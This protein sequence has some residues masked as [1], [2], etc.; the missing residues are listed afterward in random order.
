MLAGGAAIV[1]IV[2]LTLV[3]VAHV[4]TRDLKA[5]QHDLLALGA[6]LAEQAERSVQGIDLVVNAV[7]DELL[8]GGIATPQELER[9]AVGAEQHERLTARI[10]G[11]PQLDVLSIVSADGRLL[12]FSRYFPIPPI[13]LADRDYYHALRDAPGPAVFL[14]RPVSNR[15]DGTPTI[16]LARRLG[17]ADDRFLGIALAGLELDYFQSFYAN[18]DLGSGSVIALYRTDGQLLVR[19]PPLSSAAS[20]D[21]ALYRGLEPGER[22]LGE[23]VEGSG[24]ER[25]LAV[26]ARLTG[27]PMVLCVMRPLD[28][29]LSDWRVDSGR[30]GVAALLCAAAVATLMLLMVRRM[31]A[32]AAVNQALA[33]REAAERSLRQAEARLLQS[34]KME[35]LGQLAGGVAHDFNNVLQAV[36]GG[37]RLIA[38]RP[39]DTEAVRRLAAMVAEAAERGASVVRRLLAFARRDALRATPIRPDALLTGLREVL[40]HTLGAAVTVRVEAPADLPLLLADKGQLETALVN[41]ATNA[42][43]AMAPG[44]GTLTMAARAETLAAGNDAAI[45]PGTYIRL[46]LTDT[47]AGMDAETLARATEPFFTTKPSGRGTGLGLAMARGFAEQSGGGF[48]IRSRVGAGTTVTLWLPLAPA[49]AV[50]GDAEAA[51]ASPDG[52]PHVLLVEDEALVRT[53]LAAELASRG[54]RISAAESGRAALDRLDAGAPCDLLVTDLAMPG[55][56][57]WAVIRAARRSRPGLPALLLTGY[58]GGGPEGAAEQAGPGPLGYL[59]KPAKPDEL[60]RQGDV[61][62]AAAAA[63]RRV[64]EVG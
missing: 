59:G 22:R 12:N 11:I 29:V 10:A 33:A 45:A 7:A 35:A 56:D 24:R 16:Y 14:S 20:P 13:S 17:G 23:V 58:L 36:G 63:A 52:A 39:E 9:R 1:V 18:L 30:L 4:H 61:L 54:W 62:I 5:A 42:R 8:R 3:A 31:R 41:L 15:G 6:V 27:E 32:Y 48:A 64:P 38:R 49:K 60:I 25:M 43:D 26:S 51:A 28:A 57:G 34:Q 2:A 53:T 21:P 55:M 50:A 19:H 37:A 46:D 44:G 47:G 40:A